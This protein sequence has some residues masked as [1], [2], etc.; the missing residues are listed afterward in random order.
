MQW[1][2]RQAGRPYRTFMR[3]LR[4]IGQWCHGTRGRHRLCRFNQFNV[5]VL[6]LERL[7]RLCAAHDDPGMPDAL[8][9]GGNG[10]LR[11]A[12]SQESVQRPAGNHRLCRPVVRARHGRPLSGASGNVTC[13]TPRAAM[14]GLTANFRCR[15]PAPLVPGLV[16]QALTVAGRRRMVMPTM[17]KPAIS[18]AHVAGS[19]TAL[20]EKL[21]R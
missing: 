14:A 20:A 12:R 13:G 11:S 5:Y 4:M 7:A 2:L 10:Q 9:P 18:I 19:G 17:P 6:V 3:R 15:G 21:M 8:V 1:F 16:C